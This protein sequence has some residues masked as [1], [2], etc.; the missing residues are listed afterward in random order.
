M[1]EQVG[2]TSN[3][4][5]RVQGG[6]QGTSLSNQRTISRASNQRSLPP[7]PGGVRTIGTGVVAKARMTGQLQPA[8][9]SESGRLILTSHA[10]HDEATT[11]EMSKQEESELM[12]VRKI[13]EASA[14]TDDA[15]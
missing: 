14:E 7:M 5:S 13:M 2:I 8:L 3:T 1:R 4:L 12:K 10:S 9:L 15:S 11:P 6:S